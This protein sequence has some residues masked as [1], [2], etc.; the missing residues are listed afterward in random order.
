LC[1]EWDGEENAGTHRR[2]NRSRSVPTL[3]QEALVELILF[4]LLFFDRSGH[5]LFIF[6]A[7]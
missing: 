5:S 4:F 6:L 1:E 2:S 3:S 7:T